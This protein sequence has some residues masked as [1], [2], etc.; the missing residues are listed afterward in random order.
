MHSRKIKKIS[1]TNLK[2]KE[3]KKEEAASVRL[4]EASL[5]KMWSS[6]RGEC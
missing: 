3:R 1:E 6:F 5:R 4:Q 2:N